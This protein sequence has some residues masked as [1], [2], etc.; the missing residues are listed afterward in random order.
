MAF[1]RPSTACSSS[2]LPV[3]FR[4]GTTS[5][6]QRTRTT[7]FFLIRTA[8]PT[9]RW[10]A[11][12]TRLGRADI[13]RYISTDPPDER[14][15]VKRLQIDSTRIDETRQ[16]WPHELQI[17]KNSHHT[18]LDDGTPPAFTSNNQP[19]TNTVVCHSPLNPDGPSRRRTET[20]CPTSTCA[21]SG[22]VPPTP[23]ATDLL[24]ERS[25]HFPVL[26]NRQRNAAVRC[27]S[28]CSPD[29][30]VEPFETASRHSLEAVERSCYYP[31]PFGM[32][33]DSPKTEIG[34]AHV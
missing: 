33:L 31:D 7:R 34:R 8:A 15:P 32:R 17:P 14:R 21:S 1:L 19:D 2:N 25:T 16:N 28:R 22:T 29:R 6:I 30:S 10:A 12:Q 11:A 27:H 26:V 23:T 9:R 13:P 4:T 5:G 24:P 20:T 18:N 3:L